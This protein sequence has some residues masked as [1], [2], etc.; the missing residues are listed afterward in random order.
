MLE[1]IMFIF[2]ILLVIVVWV[3]GW[4]RDEKSYKAFDKEYPVGSYFFTRI[5]EQQFPWGR[6]I[7]RGKDQDGTHVFE[8]VK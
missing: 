7:Y 5:K 6:W 2:L 4:I 8:R 3:V 1:E